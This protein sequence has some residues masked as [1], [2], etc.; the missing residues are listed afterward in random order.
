MIKHLS[1]RFFM[2]TTV[3]L[4]STKYLIVLWFKIVWCVF[5]IGICNF[6]IKKRCYRII[7]L[8]FYTKF[9]QW[10]LKTKFFS[11]HC[12]ISWVFL[13]RSTNFTHSRYSISIYM[14]YIFN[15]EI[16]PLSATKWITFPLSLSLYDSK[17][18][19]AFLK[20]YLVDFSASAEKEQHQL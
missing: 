20:M 10:F 2:V 5:T 11:G 19:V 9:S 16:Q 3:Y 14:L 15:W 7:L 13:K 1:I 17:L 18:I 4:L 8:T 6:P 12:P